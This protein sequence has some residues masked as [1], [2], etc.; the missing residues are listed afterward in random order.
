MKKTMRGLLKNET[1]TSVSVLFSKMS[2]GILH[3]ISV[4]L[5]WLKNIL[6]VFTLC[7]ERNP[8]WEG[9]MFCH[10]LFDYKGKNWRHTLRGVQFLRSHK[11]KTNL[12][13]RPNIKLG[14]SYFTL[15]IY[16][17]VNQRREQILLALC[18]LLQKCK[19]NKWIFFGVK[20]HTNS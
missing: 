7:F 18:K 6:E 17:T 20:I 11:S 9:H 14:M 2:H 4:P 3:F 8:V 12:H 10:V 16:K 19:P 15:L 1:A 5:N 13:P